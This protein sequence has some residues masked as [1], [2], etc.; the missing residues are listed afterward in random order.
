M[1]EFAVG[2]F[3][4][5]PP[6]GRDDLPPLDLTAIDCTVRTSRAGLMVLTLPPPYAQLELTQGER[7]TAWKY[8]AVRLAIATLTQD[9]PA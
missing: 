9:K 2:T 7:L 8:E 4:V 5:F 3:N 1:T 6:K